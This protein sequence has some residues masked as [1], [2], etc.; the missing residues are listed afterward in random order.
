MHIAYSVAAKEKYDA[1]K[2]AALLSKTAIALYDG[3]ISCWDAKYMYNYI[4]SARKRAF[5]VLQPALFIAEHF[6]FTN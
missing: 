6:N 4:V 1:I 3:F 5:F 2:T